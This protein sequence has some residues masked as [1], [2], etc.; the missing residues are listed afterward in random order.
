MTIKSH[1]PALKPSKILPAATVA[2]TVVIFAID[3]LTNLEIA[4]A[5]LYVVVVLMSARFCERRGVV[6]VAVGCMTLTVSSYFMTPVGLKD[7]GLINT[8][9][10]LLACLL[11]TSD[12]ADE[13]A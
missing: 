13:E 1:L 7:A 2:L 6:L 9:I 12:A 10:S 11:Y 8:A 3:T 5:V 4:A